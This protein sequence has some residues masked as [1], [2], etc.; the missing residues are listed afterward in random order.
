MNIAVIN[1]KSISKNI[2]KIFFTILSLLIIIKLIFANVCCIREVL[3]FNFCST[4]Y[5]SLISFKNEEDKMVNFLTPIKIMYPFITPRSQENNPNDS[6]KD[7]LSNDHE[8]IN[9]SKNVQVEAVS[10][11]N[12]SESYNMT[13][14][15][16]K[17]KNQSN[18]ELTENL[19]SLEDMVTINKNKVLI[20]HTHTC[21]SYTPS[22][23]YNYT[24]TGNYRTTDNNYNVVRLR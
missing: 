12:I 14:S 4:I 22:E 8:S 18:Y 17:I 19:L 3:S 9:I 2:L 10:E 16:V 13:Y 20:Y 7:D 24:M 15:N 11:K 23:K 6:E 5:T 1:L 21:E